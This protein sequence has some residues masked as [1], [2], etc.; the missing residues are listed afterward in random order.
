MKTYPYTTPDGI[1]ELVRKDEHDAVVA[2]HFNSLCEAEELIREI[3]DN[4][5][6]PQ[7]EA[8][9]FLRDHQPSELSKLRAD[10]AELLERLRERNESHLAASTSDVQTIQ[11]QAVE[12]S[13]W[14]ALAETLAT[15]LDSSAKLYENPEPT[16]MHELSMRAYD[17]RCIARQALA[18]YDAA[19]SGNLPDPIAEAVK[20]ME[21][22]D[23]WP[24]VREFTTLGKTIG[25]SMED[26]R[27]RLI[28]AAKG[29]QP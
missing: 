25:A 17:M 14:Q 16:S 18:T 6:N 11:R 21:A 26:F 24:S 13:K 12:L 1:I 5:V 19:K 29:G 2:E 23:R 27:A 7:D 28:Q 9:K 3:R 4:E 15:A 10:N 22:V 8:D 20:R